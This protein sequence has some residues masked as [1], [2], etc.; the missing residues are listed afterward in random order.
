MQRSEIIES[1]ARMEQ[2]IVRPPRRSGRAGAVL[3]PLPP[4][5]PAWGD[6][7][8]L[9]DQ[10]TSA[11]LILSLLWVLWMALGARGALLV[12]PGGQCS[13]RGQMTVCLCD[14]GS[15]GNLNSQRTG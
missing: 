8:L 12:T 6:S 4:V 3:F 15:N 11:F 10:S 14:E 2:D 1:W 9:P 13:F 5:V 7:F